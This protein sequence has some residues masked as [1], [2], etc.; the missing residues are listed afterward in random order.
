[1]PARADR[2]RERGQAIAEMVAIVGLSVMLMLGIWYLGKFHD[3]QAATINAARY[4]AWERTAQGTGQ[5]SEPDLQNQVR[6]RLFTWRTTAFL[7]ADGR[8][9]ASRDNN[10]PTNWQEHEDNESLIESSNDI[11]VSTGTRAWPGT[12][13][14]ALT[15]AIE[16]ITSVM[17]AF[18]GGERLPA[19]GMMTATV[20]V[21][22]DDVDS[23]PEPWN[24][25]NI[26][27]TESS[28]VVV[29]GWDASGPQQAAERSRTF[30]LLGAL[31]EAE[32]ILEPLTTI[33]SVF[34]PDMSELELGNI[35][36]DIVPQDRVTGGT[37]LAQ[38]QGARECY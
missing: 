27:L 31:G 15:R 33:M 16:A 11:R 19:G 10:R 35:C 21:R 26:N 23:L 20:R 8:T 25:W 34:E 36:P 18:T 24:T 38:Y 30:V 22:I 4:A 7:D 5:L 2:G 1:M 32:F 9:A 6:A 29:E 37:V 13:Q 12:V 17:G 14:S 3:I 28:A